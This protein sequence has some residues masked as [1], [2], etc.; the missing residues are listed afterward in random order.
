MKIID[1]HVHLVQY[2]CGF[3]SRGDLRAIG[4]GKAQYA[5]GSVLNLIPPRLGEYDVTP[6]KVIALMDEEG[7]E[8]AVLLQGNYLGFQNQYSLDAMKKYPD[9]FQ[10]AVTYDP[11]CRNKHLI[12]E[13]LFE[14]QGAKVLKFEVSTGSGLMSAH[15]TV[16]LAGPMMEEAYE[17]ADQHNLVCVM[18]I[19]RYGTASYQIEALREAIKRHPKMKWVVCHVLMPS[20]GGEAQMEKDLRQLNLENVWF[21]FAA[22]PANVNRGEAYPYPAAQEVLHRAKAV[23]GADR[24]IFGSDIPSTITGEKYSDLVQYAAQLFT[25][26]ELE[27]VFYDNANLVYFGE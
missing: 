12:L 15:E 27:K 26:Q 17:Y 21:D 22:L 2:I 1:A 23:V 5:D 14:K 4:G 6:E 10:A 20:K 11:F 3:G 18:D 9:R 25:A 24:L 16:D 19:G 8:K 7:V 13:N